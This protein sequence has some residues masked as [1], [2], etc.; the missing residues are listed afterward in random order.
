MTRT[1]IETALDA[2]ELWAAMRNGRYWRLRRNGR[3]QTWKTRPS[4]FRIPVK[5]GLKAYA[6][7]TETSDVRFVENPSWREGNFVISTQDPNE[8]HHASYY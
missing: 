4:E 7:L 5:A 6:A 3:T 8:V 2:N 1:Q